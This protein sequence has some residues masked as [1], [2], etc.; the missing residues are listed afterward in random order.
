MWPSLYEISLIGGP[1]FHS[2]ISVSVFRTTIPLSLVKISS[3]FCSVAMDLVVFPRTFVDSAIDIIED[4]FPIFLILPHLSLVPFSIF[5]DDDTLSG[6]LIVFPLSQIDVSIIHF[7]YAS[8][9][10]LALF[11]FAL[12]C[13]SSGVLYFAYVL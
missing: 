5:G 4:S 11:D 1:I 10:L 7:E 3:F 6:S 12:V 8:A 2:Q 13:L 9:V